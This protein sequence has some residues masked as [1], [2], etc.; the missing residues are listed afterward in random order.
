MRVMGGFTAFVRKDEE[1]IAFEV[2]K[3]MSTL[4]DNAGTVVLDLQ[5]FLRFQRAFA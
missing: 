4:K 2:M 1:A 5:I 3:K